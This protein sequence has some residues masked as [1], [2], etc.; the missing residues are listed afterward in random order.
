MPQA[1]GFCADAARVRMGNREP[2]TT[3]KHADLHR[4]EQVA[5]AGEDEQT[6]WILLG[7]VWVVCGVVVVLILAIT[8]VTAY[9]V[10]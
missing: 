6:P 2:M 3:R 8:I 9:L 4:L 10:S 7:G 5:E 1:I